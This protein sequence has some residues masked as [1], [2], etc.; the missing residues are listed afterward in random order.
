MQ[1]IDTYLLQDTLF[2][3]S[4]FSE[5]ELYLNSPDMEN[6]SLETGIRAGEKY[7]RYLAPYWTDQT[8]NFYGNR[9]VF[10]NAFRFIQRNE[11]DSAIQIIE[12]AIEM[13]KSKS[14][15]SKALYNLAIIQELKDELDKALILADSANKTLENKIYTDYTEKLRLRK[16]DKTALDWQ[17]E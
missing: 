8:R 1:V 12:K 6:A 14:Y 15:V 17:L 16:L 10:K 4:H 11:L 3:P 7:A 5:W 2:W 9:K 13:T